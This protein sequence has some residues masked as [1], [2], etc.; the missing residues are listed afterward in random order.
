MANNKSHIHTY[1][2]NGNQLCCTPQEGKIYK[3]AGAEKLVEDGCCATTAK[4]YAPINKT[5]P[6]T[7]KH[8]ADD[9]SNHAGEHADDD[10]HDHSTQ[11]KSTFQLFLPAMI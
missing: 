7:E 5:I 8:P 11:E 1:D 3:N 9:G 2:E 6:D 10:G 4:V